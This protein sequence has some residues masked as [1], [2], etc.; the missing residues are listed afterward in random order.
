M[1]G[2][3]F[4]PRLTSALLERR[5]EVDFWLIRPQRKPPRLHSK[6]LMLQLVGLHEARSPTYACLRRVSKHVSVYTHTCT[7]TLFF[8]FL[9]ICFKMGI[10]FK[11]F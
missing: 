5:A 7:H 11:P 1:A 3:I 10:C 6:A 9:G 8:F 4:L 2:G